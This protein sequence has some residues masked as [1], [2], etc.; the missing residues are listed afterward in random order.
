MKIILSSILFFY[1]FAAV[2]Q[3]A[4]AGLTF[5]ELKSLS[6]NWT[7]NMVY[8]AENAQDT[9]QSGLEILDMQDSLKLNFTHTGADGKQLME[10][11]IMRIY[12]DG[13]KL[14]FDSSE[15]DIAAIRRRGVRLEIIIERE[16]VD[17][18]RSAD[19]QQ[20]LIIGPATLNIIKKIRY[21]DMQDYFIRSRSAYTK[22]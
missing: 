17:K 6:G 7:G 5:K 11:F 10:S 1:S 21:S 12:E 20:T 15:Y 2:A 13:N 8:T 9:Y 19:F 3:N 4:R 16:G 14:S 18:F 22:K